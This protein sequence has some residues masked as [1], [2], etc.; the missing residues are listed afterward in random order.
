MAIMISGIQNRFLKWIY[1][2]GPVVV[3]ASLIFFLSSLSRFP[4]ETPSFFGFD[5]I[6]HFI[7]YFI[8]G[9]LL[10]RW[11][12]NVEG[13]PGK[14][15]AL[16]ATIFVG[17]IYAFTDEWHQSFVPGRDSSLFDVLFDSLGVAVASFS[18]PFLLPRVKKL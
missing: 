6:V 3:Y 11:F 1:L 5:K 7:E 10:Y 4:D 9:A 14:R 16:I 8:L 18:F 12:A 15:R 17:I 2:G 13:L